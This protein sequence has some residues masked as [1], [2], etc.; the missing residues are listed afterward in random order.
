MTEVTS[1]HNVA[2]KQV[3]IRLYANIKPILISHIVNMQ[4]HPWSLNLIDIWLEKWIKKTSNLIIGYYW[5]SKELYFLQNGQDLM[6]ELLLLF[7]YRIISYWQQN[8]LLW[9]RLIT[10]FMYVGFRQKNWKKIKRER[11]QIEILLYLK[12]ITIATC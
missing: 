8:N 7:L 10:C 9:V 3:Y 12:I 5:N 11:W 6:I 2:Y 1:C 4:R